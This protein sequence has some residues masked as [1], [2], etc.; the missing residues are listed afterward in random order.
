MYLAF[1][2]VHKSISVQPILTLS[3]E[4]GRV[5]RDLPAQARPVSSENG[6]SLLSPDPLGCDGG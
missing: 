1:L 5:L 4:A 3:K 6:E 2:H